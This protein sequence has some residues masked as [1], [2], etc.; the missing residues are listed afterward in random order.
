MAES[1]LEGVGRRNEIRTGR[2]VV[3]PAPGGDGGNFAPQKLYVVV[4]RILA[5]AEKG[6]YPSMVYDMQVRGPICRPGEVTK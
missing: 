1:C 5:C 4:Q 2:G 3:R 6:D